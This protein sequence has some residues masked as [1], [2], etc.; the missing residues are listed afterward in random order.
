MLNVHSRSCNLFSGFLRT[1]M[2]ACLGN[3]AG[4]KPC[5]LRWLAFVHCNIFVWT[6][7]Y[8]LDCLKKVFLSKPQLQSF[9][10]HCVLP[11]SC[12]GSTQFQGKPSCNLEQVWQL[13]S[14]QTSLFASLFQAFQVQ[15]C[16]Y[17]LC[18]LEWPWLP[19]CDDKKSLKKIGSLSALSHRQMQQER[20]SLFYNAV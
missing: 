2:K 20:N 9:C 15:Y 10:C 16:M 4:M 1:Q 11:H 7:W 13:V 12:Q 5:R 8:W 17:W 3:K 14:E 6:I 18:A 19:W